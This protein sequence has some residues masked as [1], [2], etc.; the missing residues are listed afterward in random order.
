LAAL[1]YRIKELHADEIVY[2]TGFEQ[3]QHFKN[4]INIAQAAGWIDNQ[5]NAGVTVATPKVEHITFGHVN[6]A[7]GRRFQTRSGNTSNLIDL[8]T[9]SIEYAGTM[10]KKL[11]SSKGQYASSDLLIAEKAHV[12]GMSLVK[13]A[14]LSLDREKSY[15]FDFE[16]RIGSRHIRRTKNV[17]YILYAYC[18]ANSLLARLES[19]RDGNKGIRLLHQSEIQL[20]ILLLQFTMAIQ[21]TMEKK[22]PSILADYC[23]TLARQFNRFYQD[24]RVKGNALEHSRFCITD[25]FC[26]VL[27]TSLN[28]LGIDIVQQL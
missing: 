9:R 28:L 23:W 10:L 1:R 8:L 18:R 12:V 19:K 6:R 26:E 4:L 16:R 20:A 13:Y 7:D 27:R 11:T 22:K 2:V 21:R 17:L 15:I 25:K 14:E 24:C 3:K 5:A